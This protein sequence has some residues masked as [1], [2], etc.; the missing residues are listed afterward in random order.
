MPDEWIDEPMFD[1]TWLNYARQTADSQ[2]HLMNMALEERARRREKWMK[3]HG[4][5]FDPDRSKASQLGFGKSNFF[6]AAENGGMYKDESKK[7]LGGWI[8]AGVLGLF[9][10]IGPWGW[11]LIVV[12]GV[13]LLWWWIQKRK[14][15]SGLMTGEGS[16]NQASEGEI[17]TSDW[18]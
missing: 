7:G 9:S 12:G 11:F 6:I 8:A 2:E 1:T 10:M 4:K 13:F 17:P 16:L 15:K 18:S 5:T 3:A 14:A